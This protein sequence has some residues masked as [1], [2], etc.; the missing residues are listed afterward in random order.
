M[1]TITVTPTVVRITTNLDDASLSSAASAASALESKNAAAAS[2][3]AAETAQ[4]AAE[5]AETHAETAE[6]NAEAA[7]A[8]AEA[9]QTAAET[10]QTAAELA[11]TH[12]ETAE[13]NAEA[14]QAAA[15]TAQGL[16][17]DAR[18]AAFVNAN[19]YADI[20]TGLAAVAEGEQFMVVDGDEIV[21]YEDNS[22]S[23]VDV[24]RY[25]T[26]TL[27]NDLS[28][29]FTATIDKADQWYLGDAQAIFAVE[30][31]TGLL[32]AIF[33]D[34]STVDYLSDTVIG[35]TDEWYAGYEQATFA[36]VADDMSILSCDLFS[37]KS[38]EG[39]MASDPMGAQTA[40]VMIGDSLTQSGPG[41]VLATL[42]G[43][44]VVNLGRGSQASRHIAARMGAIPVEVTVT[45]NQ[46]ASGSNVLTH[47]NGHAISGSLGE[48]DG[49]DNQ[50]LSRADSNTTYSVRAM[51]GSVR[52]TLTRT[53]SGG[54]PSTSETY[55]FVPDAGEYLPAK[56][57]AGTLLIAEYDYGNL[58]H[59]IWAGSNDIGFG[60]DEER[61]EP[62][63]RAI[64]N[65]LGHRRYIA[66]PPINR[67]GQVDYQEG[68]TWWLKVVLCE[69]I[70]AG[71]AVENYV[72][73]R[74]MMIDQGLARVEITPTGTDVTDIAADTIPTSLKAD[75][76][77]H[78]T[79]GN[80]ALAE[81]IAEELSVRG[82]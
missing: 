48:V 12:A 56:C 68:G 34:G 38:L 47:I 64:I 14:A 32:N 11:E 17:E 30:D 77:H 82:I 57:P 51:I 62:N 73:I 16:A 2:A 79:D 40:I 35:A 36:A 29:S 70:L 10:A 63:I 9:A 59:V 24:A 5:L 8:A 6:T 46:I 49:T 76:I 61:F 25:P 74:R 31:A 43:R 22:G 39:F 42:T 37:G 54:P 66:L 45:G 58:T 15:E 44:S 71:I 78:N 7:Q 41:T 50:F 55:T 67:T 18:D 60:D 26:A 3:T 21:R 75:F 27:V 20:A 28:A 23:E 19:V 69:Q 65:R 53:A 13:T 52:G 4:T 1:T 80:T 33:L 72:P 81:I